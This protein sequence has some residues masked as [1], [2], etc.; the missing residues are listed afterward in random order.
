MTVSVILGLT[1]RGTDDRPGHPRTSGTLVRT[2]LS[3]FKLYALPKVRMTVAGH[4]R[5]SET[6]VRTHLPDAIGGAIPTS[7]LARSCSITLFASSFNACAEASL[8]FPL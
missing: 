4:P 7:A 3:T 6:L 2:K 8:I 1:S 5:T